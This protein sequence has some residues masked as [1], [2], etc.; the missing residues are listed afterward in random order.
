MQLEEEVRRSTGGAPGPGRA[1]NRAGSAGGGPGRA[2]SRLA[3]A[4][5]RAEIGLAPPEAAAEAPSR[6]A[7]S[8]PRGGEPWEGARRASRTFCPRLLLGGSRGARSRSERRTAGGGGQAELGEGGGAIGG[9]GCVWGGVALG[10]EAPPDS[11]FISLVINSKLL[12][13]ENAVPLIEQA[14]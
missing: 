7:A 14:R 5:P 3:L 13:S 4:G 8:G 6:P 1:R 11:E 9:G 2:F 10:T 12:Y